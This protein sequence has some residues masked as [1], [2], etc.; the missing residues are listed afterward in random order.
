MDLLVCQGNKLIQITRHQTRTFGKIWP[1]A[2]P[3]KL[4]YT[5]QVEI[6]PYKYVKQVG[7]GIVA[8]VVLIYIYFAQ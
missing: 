6:T 3:F 2:V 4:E 8:I 1:K 5:N 7:I